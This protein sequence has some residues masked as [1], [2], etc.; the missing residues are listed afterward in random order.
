M[1]D[2][3]RKY[4]PL[5]QH[6]VSIRLRG[7]DYSSPGFYFVTVCVC[8]HDHLLGEVIK[9]NMQLSEIG[10]ITKRCW[11]GIP[12]HFHSV[13]LDEYQIMPNHIHGI[14][15]IKRTSVGTQH[16]VSLPRRF[17]TMVPQSIS[18]IIR[19]FKAAVTKLCHERDFYHF[20]WQGRFY[21]HNIRNEEDL[22]RVREYIKYNPLNWHR[23]RE[24]L[25]AQKDTCLKTI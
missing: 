24:N 18:A 9:N 21:D 23:D 7:Y 3:P 2:R 10:E 4:N 8:D 11:D 5:K 13:E 14:L 16:V 6:R 17:S 1:Y 25:D 15:I 19:S 20:Q 12:R 22:E